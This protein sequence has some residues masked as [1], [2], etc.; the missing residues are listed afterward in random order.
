MTWLSGIARQTTDQAGKELHHEEDI[1][2][3]GEV[4]S[5]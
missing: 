2:H 3:Q 5:T 4:P 1:R